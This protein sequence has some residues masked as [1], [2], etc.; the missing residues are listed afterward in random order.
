MNKITTKIKTKV[1]AAK[2]K[3][4]D[5]IGDNPVLCG[6]ILGG[7]TMVAGIIWAGY[8][9]NAGVKDGMVIQCNR[10]NDVINSALN[11]TKKIKESNE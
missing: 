9:Y 3:A 11:L 4:T 8:I 10:D 5:F 7:V 6:Y 2:E 1:E